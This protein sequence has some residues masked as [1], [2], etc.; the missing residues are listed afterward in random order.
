[1]PCMDQPLALGAEDARDAMTVA[2]ADDAQGRAIVHEQKRAT[3]CDKYPA[4]R[5][6]NVRCRLRPLWSDSGTRVAY[7]IPCS[8]KDVVGARDLLGAVVVRGAPGPL[9]AM[10]RD[11]GHPA[12][13]GVA[14][15]RHG[16]ICDERGRCGRVRGGGR[17]DIEVSFDVRQSCVNEWRADNRVAMRV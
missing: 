5:R 2:F 15:P 12:A 11:R 6:G 9:K 4:G 10:H 13:R 3:H 1:M 17:G 7:Q 16:T 8:A 14:L